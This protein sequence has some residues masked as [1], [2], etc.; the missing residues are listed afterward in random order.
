MA[1]ASARWLEQLRLDVLAQ[2]AD[3]RTA[4]LRQTVGALPAQCADRACLV[5]L[6]R[7]LDMSAHGKRG[8]LA[9]PALVDKVFNK[10]LEQLPAASASTTSASSSGASM[11]STYL[12][13]VRAELRQQH[14]DG[15]EAWL[16][17]EIDSVRLKQGIHDKPSLVDFCK[18]LN[19]CEHYWGSAEEA[20]ASDKGCGETHERGTPRG[21]IGCFFF[22]LWSKVALALEEVQKILQIHRPIIHDGSPSSRSRLN[23]WN[24][25]FPI[26]RDAAA[27]FE[28]SFFHGKGLSQGPYLYV[29]VSFDSPSAIHGAVFHDSNH[30]GSTPCVCVCVFDVYVCVFFLLFV[31]VCVFLSVCVFCI[32]VC[33]LC[34][35]IFSVCACVCFCVC[36]CVCMFFCWESFSWIFLDLV[37]ETLG[38]FDP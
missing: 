35:C 28:P 20:G 4:W 9:K 11:I 24:S 29:H 37:S 30:F 21:G 10:L 27:L 5:G 19:G 22:Q 34:V 36:V 13:T 12:R 23:F 33:F 26:K 14:P 38:Q 18:I 7:E 16:K 2:D 6:C 25:D 17:A 15:R 1:S 31:C 3:Q 32:R 8:K